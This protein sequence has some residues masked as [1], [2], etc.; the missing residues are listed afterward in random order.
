MIQTQEKFDFLKKNLNTK[1]S[2]NPV[3]AFL[4]I[5]PRQVK[6]CAHTK[7]CTEIFIAVLFVVVP[8]QIQCRC[9]LV[10]EWLNKPGSISTQQYK[11]KE[12]L[13]NAT[14]FGSISRELC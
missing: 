1:L 9:S 7:T 10:S 13:V 11:R 5:Y 8:S 14:F 3:I 6:I 4:G 12:L 2:H